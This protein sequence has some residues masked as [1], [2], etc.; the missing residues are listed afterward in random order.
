MPLNVKCNQIFHGA[1]KIK[2]VVSRIMEYLMAF[3]R[4]CLKKKK[5]IAAKA[6]GNSCRTDLTHIASLKAKPV[7]ARSHDL[8]F[9]FMAKYYI[10]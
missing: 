8:F 6:I 4:L 10:L 1:N 3:F 7:P 9:F 5:V 2:D